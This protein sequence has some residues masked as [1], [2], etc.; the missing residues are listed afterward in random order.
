MAK[1]GVFTECFAADNINLPEGYYFGVSAA[2]GGLADDHN[3]YKFETWNLSPPKK[4]QA[5]VRACAFVN[6]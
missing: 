1:S 3:V 6:F 4:D 5:A 2:T